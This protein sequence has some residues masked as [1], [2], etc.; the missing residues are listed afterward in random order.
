MGLLLHSTVETWPERILPHLNGSQQGPVNDTRA[1]KKTIE[2]RRE[3]VETMSLQ[4]HVQNTSYLWHHALKNLNWTNWEHIHL[5]QFGSALSGLTGNILW[6]E[7]WG[8]VYCQFAEGG[9]TA[10]ASWVFHSY[11]RR[12]FPF[13]AEK[14]LIIWGGVGIGG[15][16]KACYI[17]SKAQN[18]TPYGLFVT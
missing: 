4:Q 9:E 11:L 13:V 15:G 6:Q 16:G 5:K 7:L 12:I 1:F 17:N 3:P 2:T 8:D 18:L 14:R 10:N